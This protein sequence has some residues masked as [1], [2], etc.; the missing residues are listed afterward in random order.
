[1]PQQAQDAFL[2]YEVSKAPKVLIE[3]LIKLDFPDLIHT[4]KKIFDFTSEELRDYLMCGVSQ[5]TKVKRR[6]PS[7]SHNECISILPLPT[8]YIPK[9]NQVSDLNKITP[10][11]VKG[12]A[13]HA[14]EVTYIDSAI[15]DFSQEQWEW[16]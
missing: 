7:T 14:S 10:P 16:I 1:M 13:K 8:G 4:K 5:L 11:D 2:S 15:Y 9:D 6:K 3:N 12:C